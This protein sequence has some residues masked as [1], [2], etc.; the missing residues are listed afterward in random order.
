MPDVCGSGEHVCFARNLARCKHVYVCVCEAIHNC[1]PQKPHVAM[2]LQ[3]MAT[4]VVT[5]VGAAGQWPWIAVF[6]SFAMAVSMFLRMAASL[7]LMTEFGGRGS[8]VSLVASLQSRSGGALLPRRCLGCLL[9]ESSA[10]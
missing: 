9:H 7:F 4:A 2:H 5:V 1:L 8:V 6:I 3:A 10:T